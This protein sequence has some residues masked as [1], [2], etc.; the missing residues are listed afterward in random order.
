M[1]KNL[2]NFFKENLIKIK[3]DYIIK[4]SNK[5]N[6][7]DNKNKRYFIIFQGHFII[8]QEHT[9]N[10]MK[11]LMDCFQN[12]YGIFNN[13]ISQEELFKNIE[14]IKNSPFSD[15]K[16][17]Q[18]EYSIDKR[19]LKSLE[20]TKILKYFILKNLGSNVLI[21]IQPINIKDSKPAFDIELLKKEIKNETNNRVKIKEIEIVFPKRIVEKC[22]INKTFAKNEKFLIIGFEIEAKFPSI[23]RI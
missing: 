1:L 3:K 11:Y 5:K 13:I 14:K 20:N 21:N 6:K 15:L 19:I 8:F 9:I 2:R 7:F 4:F 16:T 17:I 22:K 18:K 23:T 12:Y 10:G